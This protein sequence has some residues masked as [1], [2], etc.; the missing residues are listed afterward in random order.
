M[1]R[2][3]NCNP[4]GV[5]F[6]ALNSPHAR[7]H[8]SVP[9]N[10][11]VWSQRDNKL[12][13]QSPATHCTRESSTTSAHTMAIHIRASGTFWPLIRDFVF[14]SPSFRFFCARTRCFRSSSTWQ[15]AQKSGGKNCIVC[16]APRRTAALI[17][18][19]I[20]QR[21]CVF[22]KTNYVKRFRP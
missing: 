10:G 19:R 11:R 14:T 12:S 5:R 21:Q 20:R 1:H 7:L 17:E 13:P 3:V 9:G 18:M 8:T 4:R 6:G 22:W 16:H 2:C 15:V